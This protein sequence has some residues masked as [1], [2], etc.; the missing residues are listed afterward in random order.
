MQLQVSLMIARISNKHGFYENEEEEKDLDEESDEYIDED[1][2]NIW[3]RLCEKF[4]DEIK[5]KRLQKFSVHSY[6]YRIKIPSSELE[7]KIWIFDA[8]NFND[9]RVEFKNNLSDKFESVLQKSIN[10]ATIL[11][12]YDFFE[13]VIITMKSQNLFLGFGDQSASKNIFS[14]VL[15]A[16]ELPS[17]I[18]I[19]PIVPLKE[20]FIPSPR[21]SG[22]WWSP[23]G[24][25]IH[26]KSILTI[27]ENA[28]GI[29]IL[30]RD[31]LNRFWNEN[32]SNSKSREKK[33]NEISFALKLILI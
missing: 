14:D 27:N 28:K 22:L 25:L 20:T 13:I 18:K 17:D 7:A 19:R 2:I 26:F 6:L 23:H 29:M 8:F 15:D 32:K 24:Y 5:L 9:F 4:S 3:S 1:V 30:N 12:L 21:A 16:P 11:D 31:E 10:E 33:F